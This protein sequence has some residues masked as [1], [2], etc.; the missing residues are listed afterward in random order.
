MIVLWVWFEGI[1]AIFCSLVWVLTVVG[2]VSILVWSKD[3][4]P[5]PAFWRKRAMAFHVAL[6]VLPPIGYWLC[7]F[8]LPFWQWLQDI[9][10]IKPEPFVGWS[11]ITW[12]GLQIRLRSETSFAYKAGLTFLLLIGWHLV[13]NV[14]GAHS[15]ER[16][17]EP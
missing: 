6:T 17:L 13:V 7:F 1:L 15:F 11:L 2:T 14:L 16:W 8:M 9:I 4:H 12:I 3:K 10:K 5:L